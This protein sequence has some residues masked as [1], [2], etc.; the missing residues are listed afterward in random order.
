MCFVLQREAHGFHEMRLDETN[1][2]TFPRGE[3]ERNEMI[4][5]QRFP[6]IKI[7]IC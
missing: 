1:L 2:E 5:H 6:I 4:I 7:N 3:M